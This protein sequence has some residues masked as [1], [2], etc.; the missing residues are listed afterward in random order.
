MVAGLFEEYSP[1]MS[2]ESKVLWDL[3]QDYSKA[4]VKGQEEELESSSFYQIR[5]ALMDDRFEKVYQEKYESAKS[6]VKQQLE[7]YLC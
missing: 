4:M 6:Y 1:F 2:F 5:K 3:A 7:G